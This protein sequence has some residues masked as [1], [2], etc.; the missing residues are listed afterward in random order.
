M[1]GLGLWIQNPV[2]VMSTRARASAAFELEATFRDADGAGLRFRYDPV[3]ATVVIICPPTGVRLGSWGEVEAMLEVL[4]HIAVH[5]FGPEG[6]DRTA[7][8]F[9]TL[10][11]R[12]LEE[13]P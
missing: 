13:A 1:T 9:T 5:A 6:R 8:D 4:D 3:S 12:V 2:V 10:V 7:V 11:P